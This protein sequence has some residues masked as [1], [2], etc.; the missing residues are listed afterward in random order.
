ML[1]QKISILGCGWLGM[2]LSFELSQKGYRVKGSNRSNKNYDKLKAGGIAPFVVDISKREDSIADFLASDT[3]VI[4][5]TSKN[6]PDFEHL[7]HQIEISTIS[8]VIFVSSTS[9][10]PYTNGIVTEESPLKNSPLA[11]I[12]HLFTTNTAFNTTIIRF[13]GLFGYTRKPANFIKPDREIP[14]PEGYINFIHQDDCIQIIEQVILQNS[15][16]Q[17]FNACADSHP[18]RR[19]FYRRERQKAGREK[20]IFDEKSSNEYKIV[21]S[22]KVQKIL[23]YQFKYSD[24]MKH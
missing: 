6:I 23:A 19:D 13:G 10:Y 5:I 4:P 8:N 16:N 3:L 20:P 15:W 22:K 14:N 11:Q 7:I 1:K 17:I 18:K 21:S 24:L 9:V 12:E 2:P